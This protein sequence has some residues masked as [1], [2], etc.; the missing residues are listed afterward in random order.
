[1]KDMCEAAETVTGPGAVRAVEARAM[2]EG[3]RGQGDTSVRLPL[4]ALTRRPLTVPDGGA[5]T[6]L[7]SIRLWHAHVDLRPTADSPDDPSTTVAFSFARLRAHGSVRVRLVV[8]QEAWEKAEEKA[9]QEADSGPDGT[10]LALGQI[11][12]SSWWCQP[13]WIARWQDVPARTQ[14]LL[15]REPAAGESSGSD[16]AS[17]DASEDGGAD[18]TRAVSAGDG[19]GTEN[20]ADGGDT[21][22]MT[23]SVWHLLVCVTS[24]DIRADLEGGNAFADGGV[25]GPILVLS[26]NAAGR[27]R[28]DGDCLLE[29]CGPDPYALIEQT[30]TAG[31]RAIRHDAGEEKNNSDNSDNSVGNA[32]NAGGAN[33]SD[34]DAHNTPCAPL[35]YPPQLEGFGWCTWDSLR[36][37]VSEEAI[38]RA[39][40]ALKKQGRTPDWVLID[41]GWST[42]TADQRLAGFGARKETFPHGLVH[43]VSVLKN[44]YGVRHV[45]VWQAFHGYWNGIDPNFAATLDPR[46]T[47]TLPD[48]TVLPAADEEGSRLFWDA[49]DARLAAAG[50]DFVK[51]DSQ[52]SMAHITFGL[53][54]YGQ[55]L[56]GRH[57][58][59]E[60]AVAHNGLAL[61]NCMGMAPENWWNRRPGSLTR[62]SDDFLPDNPGSLAAHALQNTFSSLLLGPIC[63]PDWDMFWTHG[64]HARAQALL[65][66][67]S[68]G[69][70]YVS[71]AAG[72]TDIRVLSQALGSLAQASGQ[73]TETS[74]KITEEA[75]GPGRFDRPPRPAPANLLHDPRRADALPLLLFNSHE[76]PMD[77]TALAL[78]LC[79]DADQ[80]VRLGQIV[81]QCRAAGWEVSEVVSTDGSSEGDD[82]VIRLSYGECRLLRL[83]LWHPVPA[84]S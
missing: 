81:R 42:V 79:P 37:T 3:S 17:E 57:R 41:D 44:T 43:T 66:R 63:H 71:D 62:T 9:G 35:P 29:A 75:D 46:M 31:L 7:V 50:I 40:E 33:S 15:W 36:H 51:V 60:R 49:W 78:G 83:R 65:R 74:E 30:M 82:D 5:A 1:M 19:A 23:G 54:D 28:L 77:V 80:S 8:G 11:P 25:C 24:G 18:G 6:S 21:R 53:C 67:M 69:P 61:I 52:G 38:V 39:V 48:G 22:R 64:P 84:R 59:L 13:S 58:G 76:P 2:L 12:G 73:I 34:A 70:V 55:S 72:T 4:S 16:D 56:R 26:V 32:D 20:G 14:M 45:G 27:S 68:G 10:I 47:Q